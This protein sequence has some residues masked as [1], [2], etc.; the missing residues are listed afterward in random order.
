MSSSQH[1]SAAPPANGQVPPPAASPAKVQAPT[2][3]PLET[4]TPA[5]PPCP[6]NIEDCPE[7]RESPP[8]EQMMATIEEIQKIPGLMDS[9]AASKAAQC[10]QSTT[11]EEAMDATKWTEDFGGLDSSDKVSN[12]DLP[13]NP[14]NHTQSPTMDDS[15]ERG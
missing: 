4:A 1:T 10:Y 15:Q 2:S 9:V 3:S 14:A 13:N 12:K 7:F 11:V 8:I 6:R 5:P